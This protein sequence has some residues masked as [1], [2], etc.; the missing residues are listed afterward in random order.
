VS[1]QALV[2]LSLYGIY[3]ASFSWIT[4]PFAAIYKHF[5]RPRRNLKKRY[6]G[7]WAIVTGASDGIG[8]SICY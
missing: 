4:P 3:K 5:I 8:E 1:R 6:G 7:D 2:A